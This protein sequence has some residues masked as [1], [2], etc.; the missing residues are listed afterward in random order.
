[1]SVIVT[2]VTVVATA[3]FYCSDRSDRRIIKSLKLM[4]FNLSGHYGHYSKNERSLQRSLRS[5]QQK[6]AVTTIKMSSY[7]RRCAEHTFVETRGHSWA[8]VIN[9]SPRL[10]RLGR[11]GTTTGK[12]PTGKLN[13]ASHVA[14]A[15]L[16]AVS[17][18][19]RCNPFKY[20]GRL[21]CTPTCPDPRPR[22]LP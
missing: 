4:N 5:L 22:Q 16:L 8:H 10:C 17:P 3:H 14:Q 21:A 1:M 7:A 11:L 12:L 19:Q 15:T 2:V 18:N 6:K 9:C 20:Y 13:V